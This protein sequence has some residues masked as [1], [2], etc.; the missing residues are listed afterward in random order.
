MKKNKVILISILGSLLLIPFMIPAKAA[1]AP[2]VGVLEEN[3]ME[4]TLS[5]NWADWTTSGFLADGVSEAIDLIFDQPDGWDL[6][7]IYDDWSYYG[8]ISQYTFSW[9]WSM[10]DTILPENTSDFL[11]D[12]SIPDN[13]TYTSANLYTGYWHPWGIVEDNPGDPDSYPIVND[14]ASFALQSLYGGSGFS[15]MT[16]K[17]QVPL[18]PNNTNWATFAATAQSGMTTYY[19]NP[20]AANTT[21]TALADGYSMYVPIAGYENNT[22]PIT[23]NVTYTSAGVLNKATF[24]YGAS[25]LYIFEL[26]VYT[27]DAVAPETT[28]LSDF[29]RYYDYTGENISWTAT[30]ANPES[31]TITRNGILEVPTTPWV[32][33]TPVTY[34]ITDGL[35]IGNHTFVIFF[36]DMYGHI[37]ND[38]VVFTVF[39]TDDDDPV[40]TSTPSDIT[41]DIGNINQSFSWIATDAYASTY[42]INR[43]GTEVVAATAWVSGTEVTYDIPWALHYISGVT[44]YEII[45]S[46]LNGN[47]VNDSVTMT[48]NEIPPV[49]PPSPGIPGFEPLIVIGI[50][51]IGS[52]GL[53][54][55]KRKKK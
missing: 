17:Y 50:V 51:A 24:E 28:S 22:A 34:N 5:F 1:P 30:D 3:Y 43:N 2:Y 55:L 32:S 9:W 46:D 7:Q 47:T 26:D 14:S 21:V 44:T 4:Y 35:A 40:L 42:T 45:F 31:Y 13:I 6:F 18:A 15:P 12:E 27:V 8:S 54:V 10:V 29:I 41:V 20:L 33:G 48:V 11:S 16:L 36:E 52:I 23:V 19:A 25:V 49:L 37:T 38:S 53:I 39:V